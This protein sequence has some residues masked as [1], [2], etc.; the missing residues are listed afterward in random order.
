MSQSK[1]SL[2]ISRLKYINENATPGQKPRVLN[3][4]VFELMEA[5]EKVMAAGSARFVEELVM[6]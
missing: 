6:A 4:Y 3:P 2:L 5:M 1:G